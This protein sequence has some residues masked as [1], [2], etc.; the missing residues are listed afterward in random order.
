VRRA[1]LGDVLE[2]AHSETA[3]AAAAEMLGHIRLVDLHPLGA[4]VGDATPAQ[5]PAR[6]P[7][8][9]PA[10]EADRLAVSEPGSPAA[11]AAAGLSVQAAQALAAG[12]DI[13]GRRRLARARW[14]QA[15]TLLQ[16]GDAAGA[17]DSAARCRELGLALLAEVQAAD[18]LADEVVG[19]FGSF[20]VTTIAAASANGEPGPAAEQLEHAL[21][22]T[23]EGDGPRA[24]QAH[25][26]LMVLTL[27]MACE[28]YAQARLH[29]QWD[30]VATAV[31]DTIRSG[32]DTAETLRGHVGEGPVEAGEA[33]RALQMV[34]RLLTVANRLPEALSALD[35][36]LGLA[37]SVEESG[38]WF[39][40]FAAGVRAEH[41]G[42]TQALVAA[43]ADP[44]APA[45]A[46]LAAGGAAAVDS[47]TVSPGNGSGTGS[48]G[49]A[50]AD[51]D[52]LVTA[53]PAQPSV[54]F[55]NAHQLLQNGTR[56][57]DEGDFAQAA[58]VLAGARAAFSELA[59]TGPAA[60]QLSA[61]RRFALACWVNALALTREGRAPEAVVVGR[62]G[63]DAG[64]VLLDIAPLGPTER[65][66]VTAEVVRATVDLAGACF[67]S[68][69]EGRAVA[70]LDEAIAMATGEPADVVV[71]QLGRAQHARG[72]A[73]YAALMTTTADD[74]GFDPGAVAALVEL[75]SDAV[76]T[77]RRVHD[78]ES[79]PTT[80]ELAASLLLHARAC[81]LSGVVTDAVRDVGEAVALLTGL[82]PE[83]DQLR[84]QARD[85]AAVIDEAEPQWSADE[86]AAGRWPI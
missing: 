39:E 45:A 1:G 11:V 72:D 42:L 23:R 75:T 57:M 68:E 63:L 80:F 53:I 83:A 55:I 51:D 78:I 21:A 7:G 86:R 18:P 3:V 50:A 82:G 58:D 61:R 52:T 5:G 70:L 33:A 13:P 69:L 12:G 19:E 2:P 85:V 66:Q 24:R 64:R 74:A 43:A 62:E 16:A 76:A 47:T 54:G 31:V 40:A 77:R 28:Q 26:R 22:V 8:E 27:T 9:G 4:R 79:V 25:A 17:A 15:A 71:R 36:A 48:P 34:S 60:T 14:R 73:Q 37:A 10:A 38:P 81:L 30:D 59:G 46:D 49:G 29:G 56:L 67:A 41:D 65:G 35:D 44:V 6:G 32:R 84:A 20:T